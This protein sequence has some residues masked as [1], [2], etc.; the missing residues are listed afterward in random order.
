MRLI[1]N[2]EPVFHTH[3]CADADKGRLMTEEELQAFM[4]EC[5]MEEYAETGATVTK[6]DKTAAE[7]ADF[8]F[9]SMDKIINV[10][11][12]CCGLRS[13]DLPEFDPALMQED[14]RKTGRIPRLGI[15]RTWCV[16]DKSKDGEPAV[17]GGSFCLITQSYSLLPD[18]SNPELERHLSD[19]ELADKY[20]QA[21]KEFD[22]S[23][24]EPYLDKDYHYGSEWVFD[25]LPSRYELMDYFKGKLISIAEG[26]DYPAVSLL[27]NR[28]EHKCALLIKQK[29]SSSVLLLETENGRIVSGK[30]VEKAK[31][32]EE[33]DLSNDLYQNH[34]DH[35]GAIMDTEE[36]MKT[37]FREVTEKGH[38]F[39]SGRVRF[40]DDDIDN[41]NVTIFSLK[42]GDGDISMLCEIALV[43]RKQQNLFVS[44]F[45]M[46]KG[47]DLVVTIDRIHEWDNGAEATIDCSSGE[48]SFS[49]FAVDYYAN[50]A[51]YAIGKKLV[52]S[53]AALAMRA[54]LS[55]K[56]FSF[57]GQKAI[58]WLAKIGKGPEYDEN[59]E[60]RPVVFGLET[61]VSYLDHNHK[62]PDEAEFQSPVNNISEHSLLGVDFWKA[63]IAIHRS[64]EDDSETHVPLYF[65]KD[66]I[67]DVKEK[68]PVRG[69]LWMTGYVAGENEADDQSQDGFDPAIFCEDFDN[70]MNHLDG[71]KGFNDLG[72]I[73]KN[74]GFLTLRDGYKFDAFKTWKDG[75]TEFR[76]YCCKAD[77]T[78]RF[79]PYGINQ[80][81]IGDFLDRNIVEGVVPSKFPAYS[82][83]WFIHESI[84]YEAAADVPEALDYFSMPFT[85]GGVTQA[86]LLHLLPE[87]LTQIYVHTVDNLYIFSEDTLNWVVRVYGYNGLDFESLKPVVIMEEDKATVHYAFH[88]ENYHVL[89]KAKVVATRKGDGITFGETEC[90][91]I[92]GSEE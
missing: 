8:C 16:S 10:A 35:I 76:T 1:K 66:M 28:L 37:K 77:S 63:D 87:L 53:L 17:C 20:A 91:I 41:E 57:E 26:G 54:E 72:F 82:D 79:L 38:M 90:E 33:T 32:Y 34:G 86:W 55:P 47:S 39:K 23:I 81:E 3:H 7:Q 61:L 58:D 89:Y 9:T 71:D 40:C 2:S 62:C 56:S 83:D 68:D 27:Y 42:N 51:K 43:F 24:V 84:P 48:F 31:G 50:K 44:M 6:L 92:A 64:C 69:W 65:R 75:N 85:V 80:N 46:M 60:V 73:T 30:M 15:V 70:F 4:V 5:L 67:P 45:P 19:M 29:K 59:G 14:Y 74:L 78:T 49:F 25:E 11:V 12:R 18:Q 36:F 88:D 52:V 22:A 13:N 21:W